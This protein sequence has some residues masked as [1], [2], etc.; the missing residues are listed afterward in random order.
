MYFESLNS[1]G[2]RGDFNWGSA[3]LIESQLKRVLAAPSDSK[4]R[5]GVSL[6]AQWIKSAYQCRGHG[7]DPWSGKISLAAEQL[8]LRF[9][10]IEPE[11]WSVSRNY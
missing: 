3:S 8:S 11:L 10:T 1:S 7:F 6:V 5:T 9:T 2:I 4:T